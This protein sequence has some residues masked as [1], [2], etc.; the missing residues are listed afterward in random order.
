MN[1]YSLGLYEKALPNHLP[2][3]QKLAETKKA[4]FNFFEMSIDESDEKLARLEWTRQERLSLVKAM[5]ETGVPIST[6]CLSGHRRFPLGSESR[7]VQNRSLEIMDD[8]IKLASDL[9][10]RIIQVAGYDEYY[11]PSNAKTRDIFWKNIQ[12]CVEMAAKS[13]VILAFE[14]METDFM[15]T[16]GKAM[17]YVTKLNSPY[18]KVYPDIGNITNAAQGC[19]SEAVRDLESGRGQLAALHLKESKPG[20]FREVPFGEGHVDFRRL[21]GAARSLGV[22]LFVVEFWC[23]EKTNW[24]EAVRAAHK[25]FRDIFASLYRREKKDG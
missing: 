17:F 22:G 4:G 19:G 21:I 23:D 11:G 15:N 9:G 16:T 7:Q 20:I 24:R 12:L 3:Q 5:F 6:I 13:G 8:A 18:L 25:F 2:L 10:V 1:N 14:T